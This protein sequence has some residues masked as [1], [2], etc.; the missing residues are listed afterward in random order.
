[1]GSGA[2]PRASLPITA[3]NSRACAAA[4]ASRLPPRIGRR[5]VSQ[6]ARSTSGRSIRASSA[7]ISASSSVSRWV[8]TKPPII[9]SFSAVP[10]CVARYNKR[11]RLELFRPSSGLVASGSV[12]TGLSYS[13]RP[14]QCQPVEPP[15]LSPVFAPLTSLPGIGPAVSKLIARAAGGERV[16]DLLFH[17]PESYLDRRARPRSGTRDPALSRPWRWR[18]C[19]TNG[20]RIRGSRGGLSCGM[21]PEPRTWCSFVSRVRRKCRPAR[22]LLVSGKIDLF[23]G[24]VTIAHPEH[25]VSAAESAAYSGDRAGMA[26]DRRPV[27]SPGR[28]RDRPRV[29]S[30]AGTSR[31]GTIPR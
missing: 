23:N 29:G 10:R 7:S 26:S 25:L 19:G 6:S 17:M 2:K 24:R 4:S 11:R 9:R 21:K 12:I 13:R 15:D 30:P 8:R 16:I 14:T 5:P 22:S 3:P 1:M 20:P 18:W 27:A 31:N 28:R